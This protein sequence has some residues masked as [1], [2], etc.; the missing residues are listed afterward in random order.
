MWRN[1]LE[2]DVCDIQTDHI[3]RVWSI[4]RWELGQILVSRQTH[5]CQ[6]NHG[7]KGRWGDVSYQVV[8]KLIKFTQSFKAVFFKSC[9]KILLDIEF[10]VDM[11]WNI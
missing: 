6:G 3:H 2:V 5:S 4:M 9:D 10:T 11:T 1:D 8:L 7:V